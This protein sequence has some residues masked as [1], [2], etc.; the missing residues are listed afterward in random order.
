MDARRP[1]RLDRRMRIYLALTVL[2]ID[3]TGYPGCGKT[4]SKSPF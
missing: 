3:K 2:T 4:Q 1:P